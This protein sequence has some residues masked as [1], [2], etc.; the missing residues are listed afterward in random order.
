MATFFRITIPQDMGDP[1]TWAKRYYDTFGFD[2]DLERSDSTS[3]LAWADGVGDDELEEALENDY[4]EFT[5]F[6][7]EDVDR[8]FGLKT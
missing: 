6:E 7:V 4:I 5:T 3:I 1:N 2:W 8:F